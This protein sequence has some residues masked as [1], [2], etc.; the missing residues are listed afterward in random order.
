MKKLVQV[1]DLG[2]FGIKGVSLI[3]MPNEIYSCICKLKDYEALELSPDEMQQL[4]YQN[5][6]LKAALAKKEFAPTVIEAEYEKI[7]CGL[8]REIAS[9]LSG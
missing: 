1:D 2:N 3:E 9:K 5:E 8:I 6:D 7:K 4:I